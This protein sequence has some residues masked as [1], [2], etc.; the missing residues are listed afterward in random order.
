MALQARSLAITVLS[1]TP[2]E[3]GED[4]GRPLPQTVETAQLRVMPPKRL[5]GEAGGV[6]EPNPPP[7]DGSSVF[8]ELD[9]FAPADADTAD[10]MLMELASAPDAA[11]WGFDGLNFLNSAPDSYP[12]L[13]NNFMEISPTTENVP[14]PPPPTP[15]VTLAQRQHAQMQMSSPFDEHLEPPK[16]NNVV[17][18]PA[19][20]QDPSYASLKA[21]LQEQ[22]KPTAPHNPAFVPGST[23]PAMPHTRPRPA[24]SNSTNQS[25][26]LRDTPGTPRRASSGNIARMRSPGSST[27]SAPGKSRVPTAV[28]TICGKNISKNGAN[29]RRH[30]QACRRQRSEKGAPINA[31]FSAPSPMPTPLLQAAPG[32]PPTTPIA[33]APTP[34]PAAAAAA[35]AAAA[36]AAAAW[37]TPPAPYMLSPYTATQAQA[38]SARRDTDLMSAVQRLERSISTLDISARLCLRDAL[39]SLSNKAANPHVMPTPEQEAMNRAAE[40]LVLRMLFLSGQQVMH[41]AP[42]TAGGYSEPTQVAPQ[43][44]STTPSGDETAVKAENVIDSTNAGATSGG[45]TADGPRTDADVGDAEEQIGG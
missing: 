26:I 6:E 12:A 25:P 31:T 41:T 5:P 20:A 10:G 45:G 1:Q 28:C 35:A 7:P 15:Q 19:V 8:A 2:A 17:G 36:V 43:Q 42:G 23:W 40:Y 30:V 9:P 29:Y 16:V 3:R 14:A 38:A 33:S 34:A 21:A 37:S 11:E 39:L 18:D 13:P 24:P 22:L 44:Q 4:A 32:P 27:S